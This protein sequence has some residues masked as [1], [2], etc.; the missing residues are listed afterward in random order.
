VIIHSV[1]EHPVRVTVT[2]DLQRN[3]WTVFCRLILAIPHFIWLVVWGIA[4]FF[5]VF[6]NWLVTLL[7]GR[8]PEPIYNFIAAYLRY[9]THVYAYVLLAAN[10]YPGFEGGRG[11]PLDVEFGPSLPQNRWKT[12]FRI[13]L[14]LPALAV[15]G[16]LV[17]GAPSSFTTRGGHG[18]GGFNYQTTGGGAA[19]V[20]A[21]LAWFAILAR[22][23]MPQGFRDLV[24]FC[25]R[26]S[27]QTWAYVCILTDRYPD[28]DPAL[29]AAV[30][31]TPPS[32]VR[33]SLEDDPRR[34]RLT[35]FFR[36]LLAIPHIVWLLLWSIAAVFAL[37][38][39]W[40][41]TLVRGTPPSGLHRF[42]S[43][44]L[45]YGIH[46]YAFLFLVGGPFPGFNG[47][48]GSYPVDLEL[49]PPG[50]QGR[51]G[52]FF[53]LVLAVPAILVNSALG[54]A[55]LLSAVL[56]WFASLV[57]AREPVGLQRLGAFVLRYG[58]QTDAYV[59]LLTDR[60]PYSGPATRLAD[61]Q[62]ALVE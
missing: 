15:S 3:R 38:G 18:G 4:V 59:Y 24:A 12:G 60:Y 27:V 1:D 39:M 29:P 31:P 62:L 46:V 44:F 2:D 21:V 35:V 53:R 11:Y 40:V 17:D 23:R 61:E 7:A 48:P 19:F 36:L 43:S 8:S 22:G 5:A 25:L 49:P 50:P 55:F 30:E 42:L 56:C 26:Y 51:W 47:R 33:L 52:V 32:P 10:P 37:I 28:A 41:A 14:A 57:T 58:A 20:V 45:R 13:V 6:V 34:S 54:G 16:A 9:A